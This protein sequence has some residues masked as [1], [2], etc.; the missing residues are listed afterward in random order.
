MKIFF[1]LCSICLILLYLLYFSSVEQFTDLEPTFLTK[2][3]KFMIFYNN[4]MKNWTQSIIVSIHA[5]TPVKASSQPVTGSPPDPTMNEMNQ[6]IQTLIKKEGKPFPPIT[7]PLPELKTSDDLLAIQF[8]NDSQSYKNALDWMNT[9]LSKAH[10]SVAGAL[11]NLSN[12]QGFADF[13]AFDAFEDICQQITTCQDAQ[14][15]K[16]AEKAVTIQKQLESVFNTFIALEP[17]LQKNQELIAKSKELQ[18]QAQNGTLLPS[19]P[20]R[21]SPYTLPAGSD[22]LEKMKQNDPD[23]YKL[24]EKNFGQFLGLKQNI[25][26]INSVLR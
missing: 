20:A 18:N 12:L 10:A 7:D 15:A 22:A 9:G 16:D 8:P 4:F 14:K 23:K 25:D 21:P 6:Y 2:Y 1:I 26:G 5:D 13:N 3:N 19:A 24:Y 17:A 11:S